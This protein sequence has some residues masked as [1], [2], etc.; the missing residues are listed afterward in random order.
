[1]YKN[2]FGG[3]YVLNIV[4]Q[5][6]LTLLSPPALMFFLSWL[7]T[8]KLS[9]PTWLYAPMIVVGVIVG[10][11]SMVRFA[12]AASEGLERLEKQQKGRTKNSETKLG[13]KDE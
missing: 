3:L 4:F 10:L 1:M 8:S 6:I 11:I 12:I 2:L 9:A 13:D 5:C 7:L